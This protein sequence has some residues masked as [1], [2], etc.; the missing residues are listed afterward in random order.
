M[1]NSSGLET[2]GDRNAL[3][4][5]LEAVSHH[6]ALLIAFEAIDNCNVL[7]IALEPVRNRKG[8]FISLETVCDYNV[9]LF[10]TQ[11]LLG[12]IS[13]NEVPRGFCELL[14]H[15]FTPVIF[16]LLLTEDNAGDGGGS[17][18]EDN[19]ELRA[20]HFGLGGF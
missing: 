4:A 13:T 6:N 17:D 2:I 14:V 20:M 8:L 3:L 11:H 16:S 1:H 12:T 15:I 18:A 10:A 5:A 19:V 9:V 7:F